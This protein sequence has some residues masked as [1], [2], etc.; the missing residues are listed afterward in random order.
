[1]SPG[2][3]EGTT[4]IPSGV[5][6]P[7]NPSGR[8]ARYDWRRRHVGYFAGRRTRIKCRKRVDKLSIFVVW[9]GLHFR[10]KIKKTVL[11][12]PSRYL[13]LSGTRDERDLLCRHLA[14]ESMFGADF[15]C[16]AALWK[17]VGRH[18]TTSVQSR[19]GI[20]T[21]QGTAHVTLYVTSDL[22]M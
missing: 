14:V 11:C 8:K 22:S 15:E 3:A 12:F 5:G 7:C 9:P 10:F 19:R 16:E 2:N 1:M 6:T 13:T 21:G 20:F 17:A 4:Y 18:P